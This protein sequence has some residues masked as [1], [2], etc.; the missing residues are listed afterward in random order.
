LFPPARSLA[1]TAASGI[2]NFAERPNQFTRKP[3]DL[4]E[5]MLQRSARPGT[6]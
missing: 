3:L 6:S 5:I 1:K 4:E 2:L